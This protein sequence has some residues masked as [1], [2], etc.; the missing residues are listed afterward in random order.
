MCLF[1]KGWRWHWRKCK[2]YVLRR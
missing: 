1:F 2:W